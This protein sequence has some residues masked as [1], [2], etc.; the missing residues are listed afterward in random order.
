M[1]GPSPHELQSFI[2]PYVVRWGYLFIGVTVVLGNVG[3][4]V[5]EETIL[6][7]GGYLAAKGILNI[8]WVIPIAIISATGGDSLGYWLGSRGGRRLLLR[9]GAAL[10]VTR[11]RLRRAESFFERYGSWTVFLARFI[12]GLRFMAGPMAGALQMP[13]HRF[14]SYNIAGSIVY[15]STIVCIAYLSASFLDRAIHLVAMAHWVLALFVLLVIVGLGG[16]LLWCGTVEQG[17]R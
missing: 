9:Y 7:L 12:G 4:P 11:R 13:F 8:W 6:V 10:G 3:L 15:C 17:E 14:F 5:P 2:G 16:W 1:F